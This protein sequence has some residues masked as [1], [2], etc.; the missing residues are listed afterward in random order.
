[1]VRFQYIH[2][3]FRYYISRAIIKLVSTS[4]VYEKVKQFQKNNAQQSIKQN[5]TVTAVS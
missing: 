5:I 1:M 3:E 4:A 2:S